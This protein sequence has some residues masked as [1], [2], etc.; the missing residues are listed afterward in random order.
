MVEKKILVVGLE[1]CGKT[2]IILNMLGKKSLLHYLSLTPTKGPDRN[3]LQDNSS[4]YHIWDFGGQKAY[5]DD[6]LKKIDFY[7]KSSDKIIYVI[8]V[9]DGEQYD[10][11]LEYFSTIIKELIKRNV[12]VKITVFI[13]KYDPDLKEI[14][15]D[16]TNEIV[17]NL[18][19]RIKNIIPSTYFFEIYKTTIFTVLNKEHVF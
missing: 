3:F 10:T 12:K 1:N 9:Q 14:R 19:N 18:I 8:D 16:I 4:V 11:S 13:H 5:R 6:F 7:F 15:P 2:S 17:D